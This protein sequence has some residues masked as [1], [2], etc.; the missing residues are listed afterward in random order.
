MTKGKT[1]T[2][3]STL[4]GIAMIYGGITFII[5]IIRTPT[6]REKDEAA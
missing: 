5:W 4:A 6:K 2:I 3:T 1:E